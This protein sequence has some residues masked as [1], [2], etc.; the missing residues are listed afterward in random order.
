M[1]LKNSYFLSR[2]VLYFL[3]LAMIGVGYALLI[4]GLGVALYGSI[5]PANPVSLGVAIFTIALL[6]QPVQQGLQGFVN[7][8]FLRG[9]GAYQERA[10]QYE[11]ELSNQGTLSSVVRLLRGTLQQTLVLSSIHLFLYDPINEQFAALPDET[12]RPTSDLRFSINSPLAVA[13]KERRHALKAAEIDDLPGMQPG[14][15]SRL[16]LLATQVCVPLTGQDKILREQGNIIGWCAFGGRV[17]GETFSTGDLNFLETLCGQTAQAIDRTQVVVNLETRIRETDVLAR[18]AQGVNIM[19]SQ[20]DIMELVYAQTTQIILAD[21]FHILLIQGETNQPA[22]AFFVQNGD[23][24]AKS[25]NKPVPGGQFLEL[26]VLRLRQPIITD[27]YASECQK[28]GVL[29]QQDVTAWMGVPLNA[30][31]DTIGVLSLGKQ[32]ATTGYTTEQV[33]LLETIADQ[34]AGAIVKVRLLQV[35]EQ[36]ARQLSTLNEMTRQL[37]STLEI[38]ALLNNILRNATDIINCEAGSLLLVDDQ[39]DE[40]VFRVTVGPVA[41]SLLHQRIP[42]GVGFVGK[43]VK[44]RLPLVANDVQDSPDWFQKPDE[45]TGFITRALLVV[46]LVVKEKVTGVIEVINKRDGSSFTNDDKEL[47]LAFAGQAAVAVENVRLFTLTDQALAARVEELSVM[48]RIDRELNATLDVSRAMAI[49]LEWAM[50]QSKASAGLVGVLE[51]DGLRVMASEGYTDELAGFAEGLLP[52]DVAQFSAAI[53]QGAAVQSVVADGQGRGLLK[54][55]VQQLV[56]PIR[57]ET[58]TIG[59]ILLESANAGPASEE[60]LA[61]LQRLSDHASIAISNAQL[62]DAVQS[63]NV[64]KSEFVSF[65]SHELKNPMTSIKGYTELLAA[66]AVGTINE[67]QANFLATIRSNI[68]R[69]NTLVSDLNDVSKIEAGRLRLDFKGMAFVEVVEETVRSTRKQIE[70]KG[71]TLVRNIP[72]DLPPVWADRTRLAQVLVNLVSNAHKYTPQG[73]QIEISA[74]ATDNQWDQVGSPRVVHIWVKDNGI[75]INEEDQKKI[76]QKFFR[77]ED[78]KTREVSGTGLGLNITRSLVEMQGGK[79]WFE[80]EFRKGTTFHFTVPL[81]G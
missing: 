13:L 27:D 58:Q 71:Q 69:M 66:G 79:I 22:F 24:L 43:A 34:V 6:I 72:A 3:L 50:R 68:E 57:R 62:Y 35:T 44:T 4:S 36:R 12:G 33:H 52:L 42:S 64:A 46:P 31:A 18:V 59:L 8:M 32:D 2:V 51:E 60:S 74:E 38:E 5:F 77:S 30:G 10:R 16:A 61:F 17:S 14:D 56:L 26:E 80:S 55:A 54:G 20:D 15:K 49:T 19:L 76:F 39:T 53:E 75:G 25:E 11:Q 41:G 23:R 48:Q 65:V 7:K 9:Q 37:T 63:A 1:S 70:E 40:L 81:A 21:D 78:P 29:P 67:A 73:G 45:M 47:L 28:N